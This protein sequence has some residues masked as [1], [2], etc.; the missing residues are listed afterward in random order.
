MGVGGNPAQPT[1]KPQT[2][3]DISARRGAQNSLVFQ[4]WDSGRLTSP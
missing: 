2:V 1:G 4:G 3:A